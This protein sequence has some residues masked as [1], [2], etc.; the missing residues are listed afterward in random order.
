MIR[1]I[2]V[3]LLMSIGM[4][5][6]H[7]QDDYTETPEDND[8]ILSF[9]SDIRVDFSGELLVTETIKVY[10]TTNP[11]YDIIVRGITRE[12]PTMY[13]NEYGWRTEVPFKMISATKNRMTENWKNEYVSNGIRMYFG[14]EDKILE[15]GVYT[16]ILQYTTA[17]QLIYHEDKDEIYWNVNGTGWNM[18]ADEVSCKI[19][20]PEGSRIIENNCYTGSFGSNASLC[21]FEK[22][23]ERTVSFKS[24]DKL[25]TYEGL[26]VS[27]TVEKGVLVPEKLSIKGQLMDNIGFLIAACIVLLLSIIHFFNWLKVGRDPKQGVIMPR[28]EPPQ[29]MSPADCGYLNNPSFTP[30]LFASALVDLAVS[31]MLKINVEKEGKYFKNVTYSFSK[32]EHSSPDANKYDKQQWYGF[33]HNELYGL[34]LEKND[35]NS[36]FADIY[37]SFQ[38]QLEDRILKKGN[39]QQG[40]FSNNSSKV[41]FGCA[42]LI[43]FEILLFFY[44]V[45]IQASGKT[46]LLIFGTM[47][48]GIIIQ[49][50]FQRW[51]K[52]YTI[53]GR[54]LLDEILGFKMYLDAAEENIFDVLNPPEKSLQLF[55]KYLPYAIALKCE[56]RW[57]NK[58]ESIINAAISGGY[59][60]AYFNA[61]GQSFNVSN[62][63]SSVGS[64]FSSTISSAST[65][66][67]SSGGGSGGGGSSGG[68]GGGGGGGGW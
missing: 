12:F 52:A 10:N 62:F 11:Y 2:L 17:N 40:L 65:T 57:A 36:K 51:M 60:P 48:I 32:P 47:L 14:D 24:I 3:L 66:P 46:M 43:I 39:A 19:T 33:D 42:I 34:K 1:I 29:G 23:D 67:S 27:T 8:R 61:S 25:Q 56:N 22:L 20:F 9:H 13:N 16:Y 44:C 38:S 63:S 54:E 50:L 4:I 64:G 18:S 41:N 45:A 26:T 49:V 55:E 21:S 7:T 53:E 68:G 35:Y 15:P 37:K 58:F 6:G 5:H 30:N 28:F 59:E 31:K